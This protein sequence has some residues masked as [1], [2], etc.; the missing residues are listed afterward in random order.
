MALWSMIFGIA[1]VVLC[2]VVLPAMVAVLLAV[3]A[4]RQIGRADGAVT[5]KGMAIAGL[6]L[7]IVGTVVG[8][9]VIVII[10]TQVSGTTSVFDLEVG[11]C[12]EL[13]ANGAEIARLE[14]FDCTE[15]HGAEVVS[16]GELGEAGDEY[17][18]RDEVTM[19]SRL[20]C[21]AD[22]QEAFG[23]DHVTAGFELFPITP[24]RA[25]WDDDRGYVCLA[26]VAGEQMER[27]IEEQLP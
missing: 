16:V 15:P 10:A 14:N 12:V 5:G 17:P 9:G 2:F 18:G 3:L 8:V 7:G 23:V 27:T 20:A 26:F 4:L 13:P 11:D 6:A 19:A 1:G 21:V 24:T 25:T 22:F